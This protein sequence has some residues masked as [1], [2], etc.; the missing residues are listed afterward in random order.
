LIAGAHTMYPKYSNPYQKIKEKIKI[1]LKE[2][3]RVF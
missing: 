1:I 2:K 3:V